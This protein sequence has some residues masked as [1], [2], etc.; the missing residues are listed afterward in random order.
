M[1]VCFEASP[2]HFD[3]ESCGGRQPMMWMTSGSATLCLRRLLEAQSSRRPTSHREPPQDS[4]SRKVFKKQCSLFFGVTGNVGK[5]V[6]GC[7]IPTDAGEVE[8][9]SVRN[10]KSQTGDG[11]FSADLSRTIFKGKNEE[12][13]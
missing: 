8:N 1:E 2:W 7:A 11:I 5:R 10:C 4:C 6:P 3:L 9:K 12:R 13:R